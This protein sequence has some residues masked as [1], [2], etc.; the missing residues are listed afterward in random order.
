MTLAAR[1][2]SAPLDGG[3]PEF[4]QSSA[5]SSQPQGQAEIIEENMYLTQ[6]RSDR[7][8][9]KEIPLRMHTVECIMVVPRSTLDMRTL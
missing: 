4:S 6:L 7:T 2:S 5:G 9:S 3:E 8:D 1:D